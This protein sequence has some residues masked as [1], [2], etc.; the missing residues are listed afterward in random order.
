M[1]AEGFG[2]LSLS[3]F[4]KPAA[5][6]ATSDQPRP[7]R[8]LAEARE[9]G[10]M[11]VLVVLQC[12]RPSSAAYGSHVGVAHQPASDIAWVAHDQKVRSRSL[13]GAKSSKRSAALGSTT[14][15]VHTATVGQTS[16]PRPASTTRRGAP[17]GAAP[18]RINSQSGGVWQVLRFFAYLEEQILV[19]ALDLQK[20]VRTMHILFYLEDGSVQ[21]CD[22]K[23]S[24]GE[25]ES[26]LGD[27]KSSLGDAKRSPGDAKSSLGDTKS[28]LGDA[29][30]S[31]GDTLRAR[32]M[33]L[34]ARWVTR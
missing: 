4:P 2:I 25:A 9:A 29:K 17:E 1:N 6:I 31:L 8:K 33:T 24:L 28:S 21:V 12:W 26:S 27:A 34:R 23:S 10:G 19:G 18:A 20:R 5:Q 14:K 30:S 7:A 15:T 32:W 22:A 3:Q 11:F 13:G 16:F